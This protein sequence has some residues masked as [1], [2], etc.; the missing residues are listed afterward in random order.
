[1]KIVFDFDHTLFD[2][3]SMHEA[4]E[5]GITD[6]GVPI[7]TYRSAY[8][9]ATSWKVFTVNALASQLHK[10]NKVKPSDVAKAFNKVAEVSDIFVYPDVHEHVDLMKSDGH[11]L[12]LLSWGDSDWQTKKID[13]S[14]IKHHFNQVLTVSNMKVDALQ[15]WCDEGCEVVVVDDKPAELRAIHSMYPD[16]HFIR[17]RRE[18]G[19]YSDQ[20]TPEH[21]H[22]A[23]GMD[24]VKKIIAGLK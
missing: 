14:K 11:E 1:M 3:S 12:L 4:L 16:F 7:D 18:N 23:K 13:L 6:L 2:M 19:K 20:D 5:E 17:M 10:R 8:Y 24:E 15:S 21:M 22:E 9:K